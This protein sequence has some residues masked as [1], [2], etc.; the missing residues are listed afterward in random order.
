MN[1]NSTTKNISSINKNPLR[2]RN[3]YIIALVACIVIMILVFVY[4]VPKY[5]SSI[6]TTNIETSVTIWFAITF[7]LLF[8]M[9]IIRI[10]IYNNEINGNA[11]TGNISHTFIIKFCQVITSIFFILFLL[12]L[13]GKLI[14]NISTT[15]IGGKIIDILLIVCTLTIIYKL[16]SYT[17]LFK[18]PF[19]R[20]VIHTLLFIPCFLLN[21]IESLMH[22]NKT[23][24]KPIIILLII[25]ILLVILYFSYPKITSKIYT[26]GGKQIINKPLPLNVVNSIS[27]YQDLNETYD[28]TYQYALSFWFYIDSAAPS[29]NSNYTKYTNILSYGNNPSVQYN[30]EKNTLTITTTH[31][32][33]NTI[34]VVD[35]T[36]NLEQKITTASDEEIS[37]IKKQISDVVVKVQHLPIISEINKNG[38]RII[39]KNE[40]VLLQ[41]WNN[42]IL[43]YNGGT[44]DIFYNGKLVKSAIEVVPYIKYDTM[45]AG[46]ENG[47]RGDIANV[48]YYKEPL[49]MNKITKLYNFMKNQNPP[50]LEKSNSI[51]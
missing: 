4:N 46:E 45:I 49:E 16:L 32:T 28:H 51:L 43:N 48:M 7:I 13:F 15:N 33:D 31:D 41:K 5:V 20:L 21:L 37:E 9:I 47:I 22:E 23:T 34:S 12:W 2:L 18:N 38:K 24:T 19:V 14:N 26:S 8:F 17:N 44:L 35:A 25:E 1:T 27:T 11:A 42:I 10:I 36:H 30:A 40:N 29:M 39:Y 3:I 50:S 6:F